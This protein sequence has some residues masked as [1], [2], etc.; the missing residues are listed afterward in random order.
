MIKDACDDG[1][2]D[3]LNG[4]R[5]GVKRWIGR[6]ERRAGEQEQLKILHVDKADRRFAR[7]ENQLFAFLEHDICGAEQEIIPVAVSDPAE[8][9]HTAWDDH[10]GVASVGAA[11]KRGIHAF[12]VVRL[13]SIGQSEA[14]WQF[15]FEDLLGIIAD[16]EMEL[17]LARV[18]VVEQ[19][20]GIERAAGTGYGDENSHEGRLR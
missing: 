20:L 17:V 15:G 16:D 4:F 11:G 19:A 10:H 8:R 5:Q 2:D 3:L 6:D 13:N 12:D 9:P 7:N 1:V 14:F 18:E